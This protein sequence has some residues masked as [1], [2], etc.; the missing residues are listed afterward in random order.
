MHVCISYLGFT[1]LFRYVNCCCSSD[2]EK[3]K[4]Y[5]EGRTAYRRPIIWKIVE[6]SWETMAIIRQWSN[7]ISVKIHTKII[8]WT[9]N[10][11]SHENILQKQGWNKYN[12][13]KQKLRR[14]STRKIIP[15]L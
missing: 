8:M 15:T 13:I 12:F 6:F 4:D 2:L 1:E 7:I 5:T 14:F 9:Q 10:S 3:L 11:M